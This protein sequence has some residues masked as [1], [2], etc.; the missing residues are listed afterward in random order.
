MTNRVILNE[1]NIWKTE[2]LINCYDKFKGEDVFSV[3]RNG[4][5]LSV[6]RKIN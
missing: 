3:S 4:I 5:I 2:N 1:E 6:I